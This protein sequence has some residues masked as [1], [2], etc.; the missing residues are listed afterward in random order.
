MFKFKKKSKNEE[1]ELDFQSKEIKDDLSDIYDE[2]EGEEVD[3]SHLEK[4]PRGRFKMFLTSLFSCFFLIAIFFIVGWVIFNKP[5]VDD[6]KKPAKSI[7][8]SIESP[9]SVSSG[10]K[11]IYKIKYENSD[12]VKMTKLQLL[13]SYPSGFIFDSSSIEA[14]NDYKNVFNLEDVEAF[15]KGELEVI[16]RLIGKEGEDKPVLASLS[17]EP[18]NFSSEFQELATGS[19]NITSA[20]IVLEVE[21][22]EQILPNK[23]SEYIVTVQNN[24]EEN[25]EDMRLV[26]VYPENFSADDF[27]T[28]PDKDQEI[29]D[30][31]FGFQ[32]SVWTIQKL[33][34]GSE[35]KFEIKGVF[36]DKV[37][38]SQDITAR[39]EVGN[40]D[41]EYSLIAEDILSVKA[42]EKQVELNL[43][44]NGSGNDQAINFG[45][46]L[47]YSIIYEN[48]GEDD[49]KNIKLRAYHKAYVGEKEVNLF[50]WESLKGEN[51]G[52]RSESEI[53]WTS[54]D[55]L[56]LSSFSA[57]EEGVIDFF[58]DLK[59]AVVALSDINYKGGDLT[60]KSWAE[61]EIGKVGEE[62]VELK[63]KS[64]EIIAN[65][66]TSLELSSEARYFNNDNIAVGSGPIPPKVG[67]T[68]HYRIFWSVG[69]NLHLVKNVEMKAKLPDHVSWTEK[70]NTNLGEIEYN[71]E[72]REVLWKIENLENSGEKASLDFEISITPEETDLN[73]ILNLLDKT[74]LKAI[75][76]KTGSQLADTHKALTTDI[77]DDP[78]VSGRGLVE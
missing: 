74:N 64:N 14:E 72:S 17:Y 5:V 3:M 55:I 47:S 61:I 13:L 50:D 23:E 20:A 77:E 40:K 67:E 16:G 32:Y 59:E 39:I 48:K 45:D 9:K 21:G 51:K 30:I 8:L 25:I 22:Q 73:K 60:I 36:G 19:T 7:V 12:K 58:V 70:I 2:E 38:D 29:K 69:G 56:K 41:G 68:T 53:L 11:V 66:N 46:N 57:N 37:E 28:Q 63:V 6:E 18:E 54:A 34:K 33:D 49:L 78:T 42:T 65:I 52:H 71:E 4:K 31:P 76:S 44:L 26:V 75:D 62:E 35:E 1:E 27:S 24:S 15:G 10:E 43:I